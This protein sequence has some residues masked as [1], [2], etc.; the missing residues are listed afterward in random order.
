MIAAAEKLRAGLPDGLRARL[1]FAVG[2]IAQLSG[3]D[4][5]Y[6]MVFSNAALQWL[7][8]HRAVLSRWFRALAPGGRMVVQMPA[9]ESET[10]K[11]ELSEM[12]L[13]PRWAAMLGPI[14]H[15]FS[16]VPPPEYYAAML[17]RDRVCRN[18]LLPPDLSSSDGFARRSRAMVPLDRAASFPR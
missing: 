14:D 6:S 2:D 3:A 12:V 16:K 4:A 17:G 10:A 7:R 15:P 11:M 9:N 1:S 5:D 18:R 8:D 13:E